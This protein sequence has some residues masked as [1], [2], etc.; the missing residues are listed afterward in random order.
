[1]ARVKAVSAEVPLS[2]RTGVTTIDPNA[3]KP[4][5]LLRVGLPEAIRPPDL[6]KW[7]S[8]ENFLDLMIGAPGS[9]PP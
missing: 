6:P 1:M 8:S 9:F 3:P 7:I 2:G 5:V 4:T